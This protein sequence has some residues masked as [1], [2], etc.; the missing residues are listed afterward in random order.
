LSEVIRTM[1]LRRQ[2][3][4]GDSIRAAMPRSV[5]QEDHE[6]LVELVLKEFEHLYEG[7]IARFGVRPSELLNGGCCEG[8]K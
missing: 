8:E 6:R 1:I 5:R 3:V 4:T 2:S 7:N